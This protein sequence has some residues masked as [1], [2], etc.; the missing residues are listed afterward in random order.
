MKLQIPKLELCM[1]SLFSF[2][3]LSLFLLPHSVSASSDADTIS[4]YGTMALQPFTKGDF[5]EKLGTQ[6]TS[7]LS[8]PINQICIDLSE[9]DETLFF[10]EK[11][12]ERLQNILKKRLGSNLFPLDE[13]A[14]QNNALPVDTAKD[15]LLSHALSLA[16]RLKVDYV[17]V[18]IL[19]SYSERVGNQFSAK[20]PASASF[21]LYLISAKEKKRV[22]KESFDKT[23]QSL[24]DNLFNAKELFKL[25]GKW[26]TAEE[27][28]E[29]G[30]LKILNDFPLKSPMSK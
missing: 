29:A 2:L 6:Y 5:I 23:Q 12:D 10:M 16:Y 21:T 4:A 24:T 26:V 1:L 19:W 20:D 27:Y 3:C 11:L 28:A 15:T 18:P 7:P 17:L 9:G 30:M 13:T 22:W 8:C 25:G 14:K